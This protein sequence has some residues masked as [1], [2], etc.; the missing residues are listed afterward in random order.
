[1]NAFLRKGIGVYPGRLQLKNQSHLI[2]NSF[3]LRRYIWVTH[4]VHDMKARRVTHNETSAWRPEEIRPLQTNSFINPDDKL[5][6]V[7]VNAQSRR[8]E[9]E[10]F[11][12]SKCRRLSENGRWE[13]QVTVIHFINHKV[14][15]VRIFLDS[16]HRRSPL[17]DVG[18]RLVRNIVTIRDW[19]HMWRTRSWLKQRQFPAAFSWVEMLEEPPV[20]NRGTKT[21]KIA[22]TCN[23][24]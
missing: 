13:H 6:I 8:I 15:E 17:Y 4:S 19:T 16:R 10:C 18:S 3:H 23:T 24:C 12:A 20:S 1:M 2:S 5:P 7:K 22:S 21:P 14:I 9:G 11:A